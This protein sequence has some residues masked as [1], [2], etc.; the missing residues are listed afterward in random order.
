M[1]LIL[2]CILIIFITGCE[3]GEVVLSPED[4]AKVQENKA[5]KGKARIELFKSCMELAGKMPR[6]SDDDVSDIVDECDEA[7][8]YM[9]NHMP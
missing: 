1:K 4:R 5:T 6:Q 3:N 9:T 7:A 8:Y 2:A